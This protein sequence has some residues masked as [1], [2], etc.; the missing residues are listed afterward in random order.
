MRQVIGMVSGVFSRKKSSEEKAAKDA[1]LK[2]LSF[3][4]RIWTEYVKPIGL[5]IIFALLIR[6][7]IVQAF[8]IPTGSMEKTLLVGDYLFVSK[9]LYGAKTPARIRVPVIDKT[10]VDNLPVLSLPG[11]RDPKQGDIIV[12]EY[13]LDPTQDYIKRCV[14]VA[15]DKVELLDGRLFVNDT[16][17][18]DALNKP[19][20]DTSYHDGARVKP[21]TNHDM[22]RSGSHLNREYGL[23]QA[24]SSRGLT[25]RKFVDAVDAALAAEVGLNRE[26]V[27]PHLDAM[28][29]HIDGSAPLTISDMRSH[30]EA[31][32]LHVQQGDYPYIVPEGSIFMMGDNRFNSADSRYW[33]PLDVELIKGKALFLYWSWDKDRKLPRISRLGDLIK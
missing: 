21:H 24:L 4:R 26:L 5:A 33:G 31:V 30:I 14:A 23:A 9:F 13:P 12:F 32:R 2:H 1:A 22:S 11:L 3:R 29:A 6:Q 8:R 17:Y 25:P 28:N 15:G 19:Q 27:T 7:F 18:E 10:L 20:E 16:E